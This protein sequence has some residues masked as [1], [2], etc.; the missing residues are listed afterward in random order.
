MPLLGDA[1]YGTTELDLS[2]GKGPIP[3]CMLHAAELAFTHPMTQKLL[4]ITAEVPE[5]FK[6]Y[7]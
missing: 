1:T 3:R 5:D 4:T 6:K 7:L 2:L